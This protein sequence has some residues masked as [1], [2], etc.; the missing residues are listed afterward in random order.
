MPPERSRRGL[1]ARHGVNTRRTASF[2]LV[3]LGAASLACGASGPGRTL[4]TDL[5]TFDV[6]ATRAINDCGPNALGN[7]PELTFDVELARADTELFWDGRVGARLDAALEFEFAASVRFALRP[8]RGTDPGCSIVR[9]D[10]IAG[11]LAADDAGAV[12]GFSGEMRF[13]FEA[14]PESSCTLEE[15]RAADLPRLP[16]QMSYTLTGRRTRAPM[17]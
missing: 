16:C 12:T 2:A 4:G 15:Q 7:P 5:G 1:S 9:D 14:P 6:A 11:R 8:A 10:R 17:P 3:S 13:A